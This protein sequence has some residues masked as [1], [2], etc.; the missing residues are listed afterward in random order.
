MIG[1]IYTPCESSDVVTLLQLSNRNIVVSLVKSFEPWGHTFQH[2]MFLLPSWVS[3][4]LILLLFTLGHRL[5]N[6]SV[7]TPMI[8]A[9]TALQDYVDSAWA[10]NIRRRRSFPALSSNSLVLLLLEI[11]CSTNN[12]SRWF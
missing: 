4:P 3:A 9:P 12:L 6:P 2:G 5:I 11:L 7:M 8:A 10:M 1:R